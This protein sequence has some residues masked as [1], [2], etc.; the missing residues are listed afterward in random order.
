[1]PLKCQALQLKILLSMSL[2][3]VTFGCG[4]GSST[5]PNPIPTIA[6]ISP[7]TTTRGGPAFTLTVN[8][9]NFVSGA[10]VQWNGS[11]RQTALVNDNHLTAQILA[12]D[13]SVAGTEKVTVLNPGP[14]GGVS[15][16]LNFN[17][18]CVLAPPTP[19]SSQTLARLG[20]YY[21]DGW[22]GSDTSYHLAQIV[23][24][25]YQN[26]EPLSGWRDDNPCAVEQQL[27]WAHSFG[28]NFFIFDWVP[29][30]NIAADPGEN[31]NNALEVTHSLPDR[32]GMQYAIMYTN[33]PPFVLGPADW[34]GAINEWL[35]YMEDPAYATVNG[36]PLLVVYDMRQ[37]RQTFGSSSAVVAAFN[38]LRAAALA[39]GLPGVY[40]VGGFF[41]ADGAP[42]QDGLFPD[43]SMAVSDGY[44]AVSMYGYGWAAPLGISGA[45]PY[46]T[47]AETGQWIWTQGSSKSP[48]A[49]IPVAM[50]G[51]DPRADTLPSEL[52]TGRPLF[53]F[54]RTPQDVTTLVSDAITWAASNPQLRPER[55]PAPPL[56]IM[57]A[58]NELLEGSFI[59]PTVG[60]G[61]SYGDALAAM[62]ATPPA[63]V[64]SVLT[65]TDSGSTDPNRTA[66]GLLADTTGVP[67]AGASISLSDIP[68]T[69]TYEQYQLSGQ[70]P[71][72]AA[73]AI[74]GFRVNS[75]QDSII[76]PGYWFAGPD[77]TN[78]SLY[79]VSYVQ[80]ADGVQRVPNG[81]FS[82]GATSWT[83]Q[84]QTQIVPSDRGQGQMA[85]V[86]ATADQLATLDSV[87]FAVTASTPF[88]FS[89]FARIA[90]TNSGYFFVTFQ[91]ASGNSLTIPA[92]SGGALRAEMIPITAAKVPLGSVTTDSAGNFQFSL[93]ALGTSQVTLE[94]AYVGDAQHWPAYA[95]TGP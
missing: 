59:V 8:G 17:I 52:E 83:L 68:S 78:F 46:S 63:Q 33:S 41:V 49:F 79:Q 53:W 94:A 92:P 6:N 82:A 25:P 80:P 43:L 89:C 65:V 30:S 31:V 58:W 88:Q 5:V 93:A 19:A 44:D 64:Q 77:A 85:Q 1:M 56:V 38:Q 24:G 47:L 84:G 2:A 42:A 86:V 74:V 22:A 76:Y 91:D 40:I 72:A 34:S 20:A 69:G 13:I 9:S 18:P 15:S 14:G 29:D 48:L 4:G 12:D 54:E 45:Q 27:A 90:P 55:S 10:A 71:T 26:R 11:A 60:D 36:K 62:L 28:I 57:E 37:H 16:S 50:D 32:H 23:N 61:T 51:W 95:Q 66:S 3:A 39:D 70:A 67:I 21:F 7:S 87:P 75:D 35:P 81:D 73:Q